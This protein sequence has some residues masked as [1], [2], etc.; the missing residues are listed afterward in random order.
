MKN[1]PEWVSNELLAKMAACNM[2]NGLK[3]MLQNDGKWTAWD[4]AYLYALDLMI[5]LQGD[6]FKAVEYNNW[7]A[8]QLGGRAIGCEVAELGLSMLGIEIKGEAYLDMVEEAIKALALSSIEEMQAMKERILLH[9]EN[10][11]PDGEANPDGISPAEY[12]YE[13]LE[14]WYIEKVSR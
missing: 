7:T 14:S 5:E 1:R 9:K 12:S 6:V 2:S 4:I 13:S 11:V 3:V 10:Y 8:D